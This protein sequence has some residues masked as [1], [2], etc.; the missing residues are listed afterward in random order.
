MKIRAKTI[1]KLIGKYDLKNVHRAAQVEFIKSKEY[2]DWYSFELDGMPILPFFVELAD[3]CGVP[4]ENIKTDID[5]GG[6][7]CD[8]CG[9]GGEG[10]VTVRVFLSRKAP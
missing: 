7:G 6:G 2:G 4:I 3:A 8:T 10:H 9:Y 5:W 1:E